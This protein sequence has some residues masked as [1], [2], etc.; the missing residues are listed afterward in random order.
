MGHHRHLT[1]EGREMIMVYHAQGKTIAEIA[2]LIG[3]D[4]STVSR[5]LKRNRNSKGRYVACNAQYKNQ[6]CRRKSRSRLKLSK[7][8]HG[9]V[10]TRGK[11][12]ISHLIGERPSS[13]QNRTRRGHWEGDTVIGK[14]DKACLVTMV[15]RKSMFLLCRKAKAKT[16]DAVGAMMREMF[17]GQPL[18]SITPDR[19]KE[20]SCHE[21]LTVELGVE[22]YFPLPHHTW[23]SGTN[24]KT[25]GLLREYFLKGVDI[26]DVG[27]D[28]CL[29]FRPTIQRSCI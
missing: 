22:Y 16:S 7:Y 27:D 14:R 24:E 8:G 21:K 3:K 19:G 4:K 1:L 25:N 23:V 29:G 17:E 15:D 12:R 9:N 13:A 28:K 18:L 10:E 11:I 5:G 6:E 26:T 2:G 20:F